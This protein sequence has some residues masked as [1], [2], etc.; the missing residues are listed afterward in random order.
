MIFYY[1]KECLLEG[2]KTYFEKYREKNATLAQ[3]V[4]ELSAAAKKVGVV[5]DEQF[6]IDWTDQWL[7]SAGCALIE[8]DYAQ[9]DGKLDSIKVKQTPYN[10][11]NTPENRLRDQKFIVALLDKDMKIIKEVTVQTSDKEA[12]T[13]VPELKDVEV[14]H[15]FLM[16][17]HAHGYAK[18]K[19]DEMSI[20]AFEQGLHKIEN[21]LTRRQVYMTLFDMI[22]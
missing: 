9:V 19:Y 14:P 12:L 3:F 16:N 13:N 5:K 6:M 4:Q 2:L 18:F 1:G 21:R 8:L 11:K 20:R 15:C 7:K 10:I 17:L 22:K